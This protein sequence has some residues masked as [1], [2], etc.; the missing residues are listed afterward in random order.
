MSNDKKV[1][2]YTLDNGIENVKYEE[3]EVP[4]FFCDPY[5]SWQ[6]A[7]VENIIKMARRFF[8]KGSDLSQYSNEYIMWVENILN[9]KPRKSL[10]YKTP[11]EI[12]IKNNLFL[13]VE[14]SI[15]SIKKPEQ[16]V[17]FRG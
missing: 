4:T 9:N 6:K 10:G 16:K 14:P 5:S 17:A 2:S 1:K 12:M 13:K 15:F 11:N 8:P 7:G 3:L